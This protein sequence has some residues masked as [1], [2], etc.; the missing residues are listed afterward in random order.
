MRTSAIILT[1]VRLAPEKAPQPYHIHTHRRE[2][3]NIHID[4][5]S[6]P[7]RHIT[8][9]GSFHIS[10]EAEYQDSCFAAIF[11]PR[12]HRTNHTRRRAL[13]PPCLPARDRRFCA[14]QRHQTG[15]VAQSGA[16]CARAPN[17][18]SNAL[19]AD[20]ACKRTLMR[21]RQT[22]TSSPGRARSRRPV[23]ARPRPGIQTSLPRRNNTHDPV[24]PACDGQLGPVPRRS[25]ASRGTALQ[26]NQ[27]GCSIS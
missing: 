16:C 15:I 11:A 14:P 27:L 9:H 7:C 22:C 12:E 20:R 5:M 2:K 1:L 25:K 17:R 23:V 6:R 24:C 10:Q 4:T 18:V 13:T 8:K 26:N 19:G 21:C 3:N